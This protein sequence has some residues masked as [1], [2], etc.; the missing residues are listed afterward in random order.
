VGRAAQEQEAAGA[1]AEAEVPPVLAHSAPL[2][3]GR[4]STR[5]LLTRRWT[6]RQLLTRRSTSSGSRFCLARWSKKNLV[7]T[8]RHRRR[9]HYPHDLRRNREMAP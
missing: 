6:S 7:P 1:E 2:R 8:S 4:Q 5:R 3:R 9:S